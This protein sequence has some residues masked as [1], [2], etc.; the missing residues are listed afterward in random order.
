MIEAED[1]TSFAFM[2]PDASFPVG[3]KVRFQEAPPEHRR[4]ACRAVNVSVM[5]SRWRKRSGSLDSRT[6]LDDSELMLM[7]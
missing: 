6:L 3:Q 7:D 2:Y 1:G 5:A 4:G